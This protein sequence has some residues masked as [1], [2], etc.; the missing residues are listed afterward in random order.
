MVGKRWPKEDREKQ[1]LGTPVRDTA[2]S[3]TCSTSI[4][5]W[6]AEGD[7]EQVDSGMLNTGVP[8]ARGSHVSLQ[9]SP[10]ERRLAGQELGSAQP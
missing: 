9:H 10:A 4:C 3:G 5:P 6:D 8:L 1:R 7:G 2:S